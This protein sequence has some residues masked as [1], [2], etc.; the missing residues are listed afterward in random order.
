MENVSMGCNAVA[1]LHQESENLKYELEATKA[2]LQAL[3]QES[4]GQGNQNQ[5]RMQEIQRLR[6]EVQHRQQACKWG[7]GQGGRGSKNKERAK[8]RP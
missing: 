8:T 3:E 7:L 6:Q 1:V 4:Q 2:A 5:E